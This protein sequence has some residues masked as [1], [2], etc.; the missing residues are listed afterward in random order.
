MHES[1]R[2]KQ[3]RIYSSSLDGKNTILGHVDC[4][5]YRKILSKNSVVCLLKWW[6][7]NCSIIESLPEVIQQVRQDLSRAL[8]MFDKTTYALILFS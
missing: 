2:E 8:G 1:V 7:S 5:L 4:G 6:A 3:V